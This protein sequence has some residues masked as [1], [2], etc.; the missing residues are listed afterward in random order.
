[1]MRLRIFLPTR[2]L[3]DEAV[4]RV[5]AEG[6]GGCF[7]ILPAHQDWVAGL[8]PGILSYVRTGED[9]EA[10]VAVDEGTLVKIGG[11]VNV[12]T[13]HAV[14]GGDLGELERTI[15]EEFSF[16]SQRERMA[17]DAAAKIEAGFIRRFLEV[18]QHG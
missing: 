11:E 9:K 15:R 3:V 16:Y 13:R 7:G 2:V 1:M 6:L 18:R 17:R 4:N 14:L 10:F 8:V 12:S 5:S